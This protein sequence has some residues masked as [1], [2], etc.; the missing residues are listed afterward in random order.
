ML[1]DTEM[2]TKRD[3]L[4]ED[5]KSYTP[6]YKPYCKATPIEK[7]TLSTQIQKGIQSNPLSK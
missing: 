3:F 4:R 7:V 5:W 1:R 2:K 6:K